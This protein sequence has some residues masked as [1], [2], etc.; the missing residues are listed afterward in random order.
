M[1]AFA[2]RQPNLPYRDPE[3]MKL[4]ETKGQVVH[5]TPGQKT[6]VQLQLIPSIE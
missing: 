3:A 6:S 1:L 5:L 2:S 4:Y